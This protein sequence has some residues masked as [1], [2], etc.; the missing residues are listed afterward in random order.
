MGSLQGIVM[1]RFI[2]TVLFAGTAFFVLTPAAF[3][4]AAWAQ[5][6]AGDDTAAALAD[7]K[8]ST[9]DQYAD[10]NNQIASLPK[11]SV[12]NGRLTVTS[13]DGR[14]SAALRGTFQYDIAYYSQSQ[15]ATALPAA[16]GPDLGSGANFRRV[17][18]GL[19]GRLF[20]DW[21]YNLNFDFGGSGGT[22]TPG[23]VQSVYLSFDA[24]APWSLRIGAYP[25]P[26]SVEDATSAADTLFLE[27]NAPSDLQRNIA[28]GDGRN[29]MSLIYADP[30]I[31]GAL[32]YTGN[33]VQ[34]GAKALAA[35]GAAQAANFDEQQALVGRLSWLAIA[36]PEVKWLVGVNG[37][38]VLK[39]PDLVANGAPTLAATPGAPARNS[40]T[41]SANPE[42]TVD[43]NGTSLANTGALPAGHVSQWGVETAIALPSL[44]DQAGYYGF[45]VAR[46]PLA[47]NRFTASGVSAPAVVQPSGNH[48]S[49][50]YVQA[51][52][53][54][55]GESRAYN[56][57]TG[58]FTPPKPAHPFALNGS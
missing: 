20:A 23:H 36:T 39:L 55:T 29:A 30:T 25:P 57:G 52:W 6:A 34:D 43:S 8:R 19:S 28:G 50:W 33:K 37:T 14:F 10:L 49:G 5:R 38:Y 40:I 15:A 32:S 2:Q 44:Y 56:Q 1:P 26:T 12:D 3:I 31:F 22:E 11:V 18:L 45:A 13:G 4:P 42:L 58:A 53:A 27:R 16:Y 35:A 51:A 9:S 17:Y 46:S 21:S 47:Y 24:L 48:F 54:L 41:L 7:L